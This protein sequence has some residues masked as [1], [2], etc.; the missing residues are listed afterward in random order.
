MA[1]SS[2]SINVSHI[3]FFPFGGRKSMADWS[4]ARSL[5]SSF[6]FPFPKKAPNQRQALQEKMSSSWSCQDRG[7]VGY[8]GAEEG[9]RVGDAWAGVL[10]NRSSVS[11][12]HTI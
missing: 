6:S 1:P 4:K 11:H 2:Q 3:L 8:V 9:G 12:T 5:T 7:Q 10:L